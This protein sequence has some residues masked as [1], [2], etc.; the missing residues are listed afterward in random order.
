MGKMKQFEED[1][2]ED[3]K[4]FLKDH[5]NMPVETFVDI[6]P[7]YYPEIEKDCNVCIRYSCPRRQE[8]FDL[9]KALKEKSKC[10]T[11]KK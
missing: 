6:L 9:R 1:M 7:Y 5:Q 10:I 8:A 11:K 4:Q 3:F 2:M